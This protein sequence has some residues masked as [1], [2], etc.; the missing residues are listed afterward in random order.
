MGCPAP[1]RRPRITVTRRTGAMI[2]LSLWVISRMVVPA[3]RRPAQGDEQL[4]GLLRRQHR[5]G[6]VQDQDARAAVQRL[7]DL[8]PLALAHR[9][10]FHQRVQPPAGRCRA[11]ARRAGAHLGARPCQAPVRLGAEHHVVQRAQRVDQHE[12][13]VHHADA[14]RDGLARELP[15]DLR[16]LP[17]IAICRCRPGRSRTG[18]TSACSCPRRSRPRCRAPCRRAPSGR[19]RGWPAPRRSACRCRA[20]ATARWRLRWRSG[21]SRCR[22][23][24]RRTALVMRIHQ[25]LQ[26]L[27][28]M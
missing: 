15:G 14:Q 1:P 12:V 4:L 3:S 9:Q 26:A 11:S 6:L 28:A 5:G 18:W 8:Q 21:G 13:L 23:V 2:S 10:V 27:A 24:R 20:S 7:E 25:Y 16:G 17:S 22:R 19:H